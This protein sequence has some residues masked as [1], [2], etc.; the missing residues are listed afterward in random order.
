M[1]QHVSEEIRACLQHA[2]ACASQA[3]AQNR[4]ELRQD[5]LAIEQR[6]LSLA[7]SYEFVE[8]LARF[9]VQSPAVT[10]A[11]STRATAGGTYRER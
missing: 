11:A 9:A 6:W 10:T 4:V 8:R 2:Q 5:F 1:L 3:E 7:R